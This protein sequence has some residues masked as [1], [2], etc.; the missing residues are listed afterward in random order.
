MIWAV[1]I[2]GALLLMDGVMSEIKV[3]SKG[4]GESLGG[5]FVWIVALQAIKVI[6]GTALIVIALLIHRGTI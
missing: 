1:F 3:N 6:C 4:A 2:T 5:A